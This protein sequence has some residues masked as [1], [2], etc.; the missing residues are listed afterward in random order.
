[1]GDHDSQ[2]WSTLTKFMLGLAVF[3][4]VIFVI[5]GSMAT[6]NKEAA[7]KDNSAAADKAIAE[8]IAPVAQVTVAGDKPAA[9]PTKKSGKDIYASACFACHGTGAAGAP[10]LG[11]KAAWSARIGQGTAKLYDHAINGLNGMPAKGGRADL[12]D[13]AIKSVVDYMVSQAK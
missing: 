2:V 9:A 11:D 1:V 6:G 7:T 3:A 10:I 13:D 12:S 4:V 5:A 8:R